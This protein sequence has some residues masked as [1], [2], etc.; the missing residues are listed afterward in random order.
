MRAL[1]VATARMLVEAKHV[2]FIVDAVITGL[3]LLAVVCASLAL[4]F[5]TSYRTSRKFVLASWLL[6]FVA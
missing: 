4:A 3:S 1:K 5:W 2:D 6:V